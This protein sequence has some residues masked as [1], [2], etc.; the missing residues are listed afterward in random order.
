MDFI[1]LVTVSIVVNAIFLSW[2]IK[3]Y[4]EYKLTQKLIDQ[5][6]KIK[7]YLTPDEALICVD[8]DCIYSREFFDECPICGNRQNMNVGIMVDPLLQI[9]HQRKLER[10]LQ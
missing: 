1:I 10:I 5:G 3:K 6:M 2:F 4:L 7:M 8:C 9:Q